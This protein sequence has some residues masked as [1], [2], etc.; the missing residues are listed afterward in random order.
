MEEGLIAGK[1]LRAMLE[2]AQNDLIQILP[3]HFHE[4]V[5]EEK[6]AIH[7][8]VPHHHLRNPLLHQL[9]HPYTL[10]SLHKTQSHTR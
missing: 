2:V 8:H 6:Y 1:C 7:A 3:A 5:N 4:A 10:L 9:H